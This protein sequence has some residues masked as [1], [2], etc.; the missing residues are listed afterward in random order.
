[1]AEVTNALGAQD[2]P[3]LREA[4]HTLCG[5]LC[6]F[7]TVAGSTA[8]ELETCAAAG[9]LQEAAPLVERVD[10]MV[11]AIFAQIKDLSV[12]NM[13]HKVATGND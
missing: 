9:Q 11:Q 2:A 6:A 5:L 10:S 12:E 13:R 8:S 7:S 1:L 3:R 4:T